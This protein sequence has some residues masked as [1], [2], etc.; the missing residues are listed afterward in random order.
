MPD[1]EAGELGITHFL[2][3][4]ELVDDGFGDAG[5]AGAGHR[6]RVL[7]LVSDNK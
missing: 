4:G 3:G 2:P 6:G 7:R 1:N 5:F